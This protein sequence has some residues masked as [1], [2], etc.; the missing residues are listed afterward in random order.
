MDHGRLLH[1]HARTPLKHREFSTHHPN[2][3]PAGCADGPG[4]GLCAPSHSPGPDGARQGIERQGAGQG[5]RGARGS[6]RRCGIRKRRPSPRGVGSHGGSA[7][8][9][10]A[11][12]ENQPQGPGPG[13]PGHA[14]RRGERSQRGCGCAARRNRGGRPAAPDL[15]ALAGAD[16]EPVAPQGDLERR[17]AADHRARQGAPGDAANGRAEHRPALLHRLQ[18]LSLPVHRPLHDGMRGAQPFEPVGHHQQ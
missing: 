5:T 9:A 8:P 14:A 3:S 13:T 1:Q 18:P 4:L 10:A 15:H 12:V 16:P 17:D 2:S 6:G 7:G 11:P